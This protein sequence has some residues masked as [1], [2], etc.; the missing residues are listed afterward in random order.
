[1]SSAA[2][3]VRDA[4][5]ALTRRLH[6]EKRFDDYVVERERL[7]QSGISNRDAWRIAAQK[8]PPLNGSPIEVES[9]AG[10]VA[11]VAQ[12]AESVAAD[13]LFLDGEAWSRN[14]SPA[15]VTL[16]PITVKGTAGSGFK[17]ERAVEPTLVPAEGVTITALIAAIGSERHAGEREVAQWVFNNALVPLEALDP[18]SVPSLGALKLLQWVKT[19]GANYTEFVR[20]IWSKM[21]PNKSQLDLENRFND[22]GRKQLQMLDEFERSFNEGSAE[23]A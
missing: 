2:H 22:D 5:V 12:P 20:S 11:I 14:E 18:V 10:T 1:M 23:A 16:E 4:K 13:E 8:F 3:Q 17:H 6:A 7:K 15:D 9:P 19:S 21:L